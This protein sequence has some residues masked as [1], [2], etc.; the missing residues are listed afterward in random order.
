MVIFIKKISNTKFYFKHIL[1]SVLFFLK[2]LYLTA[3][4]ADIMF[5]VGLCA[6]FQSN[7]KS[8][9]LVPLKAFLL[10]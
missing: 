3:S 2:N 8:L 9:I 10:H 1:I 6:W 7:P 4:R 5:S